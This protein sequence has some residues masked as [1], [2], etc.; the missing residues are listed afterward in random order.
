MRNT[1]RHFGQSV[2]HDCARSSGS[3]R[4]TALQLVNAWW[5]RGRRANARAM[6]SSEPG[7]RIENTAI[8]AT[9]SA[10]AA[11][12][13][14]STRRLFENWWLT[15]MPSWT[16]LPRDA[17]R[18]LAKADVR[19]PM[20]R[21]GEQGDARHDGRD[22]HVAVQRAGGVEVA[23]LRVDAPAGDQPRDAGDLGGA[24]DRRGVA[25]REELEVD[26]GAAGDLQRDDGVLAA[27]YR[28]QHLQRHRRV[29][30][31]CGFG[32]LGRHPQGNLA[33][34]ASVRREPRPRQR[35]EPVDDGELAEA[36]RVQR[37][38]QPRGGRRGCAGLERDLGRGGRLVVADARDPVE[39][40]QDGLDPGDVDLALG[41]RH[42]DLLREHVGVVEPVAQARRAG[43]RVEGPVEEAERA[44]GG[45]Y[46]KRP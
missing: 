25:D 20:Q 26:A 32:P 34:W 11:L 14:R 42:V 6:A 8:P 13:I 9:A 31:A 46:R 33:L 3:R 37:L 17:D 4:N 27:A 29:G 22:R 41:E 1:K 39:Q 40:V 44:E 30:R 5:Y 23:Q 16:R 43:R 2:H 18:S 19:E 12:S 15:S 36:L 45:G 35:L 7:R 10:T 28:D 38:E 21:R 24:M